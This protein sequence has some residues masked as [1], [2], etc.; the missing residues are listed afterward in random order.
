MSI[1]MNNS[2]NNDAGLPTETAPLSAEEREQLRE[3]MSTA[4]PGP[5]RSIRDGVMKQIEAETRRR[6]RMQRFTRYGSIAAGFVLI[7]GIVFTIAPF[8]GGMSDEQLAPENDAVRA[9]SDDRYTSVVAVADEDGFGLSQ[10]KGDSTPMEAP[11]AAEHSNSIPADTATE[12]ET[13]ADAASSRTDVFGD[14]TVPHDP[15]HDDVNPESVCT[16]HGS[17]HTF[18]DALVAH[19]GEAAFRTW[20]ES[21]KATASCGVPCVRDLVRDFQIDRDTFCKLTEASGIDYRLD[22]IF[23]TEG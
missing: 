23:P 6:K 7:L 11:E 13:D 8:L 3:L 16:A 1:Y 9:Y 17:D 5:K 20:Y 2:K 21:A 4:F 15:A 14:T 19:V 18:C 22:D 10:N 12:N